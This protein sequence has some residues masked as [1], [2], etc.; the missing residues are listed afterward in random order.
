[1]SF[2]VL[3]NS[4]SELTFK[5]LLFDIWHPLFAEVHGKLKK[6]TKLYKKVYK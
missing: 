2:K 3:L 5:Y 1:M 6:K 4:L